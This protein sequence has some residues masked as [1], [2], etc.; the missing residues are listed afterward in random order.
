MPRYTA[1]HLAVATNLGAGLNSK[2]QERIAQALADHEQLGRAAAYRDV[3]QVATNAGVEV[4]RVP[5]RASLSEYVEAM[6]QVLKLT[7]AKP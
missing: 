2:A 3:R 7:E 6:Q 4:D 5:P 1:E